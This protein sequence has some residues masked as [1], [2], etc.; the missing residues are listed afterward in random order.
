M[1]AVSGPIARRPG[2]R[3]VDRVVAAFLLVVLAAGSFFLWIGVPALSLWA[4]AQVVD[5][6]GQHLT[7]GLLGVPAGMILFAPLLFWVNGLYLRVTGA[8]TYREDEEEEGELRRVHGPLEVL[9]VWSFL[10]GV[11]ALVLWFGFFATGP[12]PRSV[13]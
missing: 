4:I 2:M 1:E 7:L 6:P 12:G 8:A 3:P 9:L 5:S 10:V 13:I 11:V